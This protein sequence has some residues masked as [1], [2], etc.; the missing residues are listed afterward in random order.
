MDATRQRRARSQLIIDCKTVAGQ[1]SAEDVVASDLRV[2]A[3]ARGVSCRFPSM[4]F[5]A[6][7]EISNEIRERRGWICRRSCNAG[8]IA[9]LHVNLNVGTKEPWEGGNAEMT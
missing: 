8:C 9:H 6:E 7:Q 4:G 5:V 2:S 3:I 1:G